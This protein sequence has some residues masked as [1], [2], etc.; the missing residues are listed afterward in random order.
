MYITTEDV[1]KQINVDFSDDDEYIGQLIEAAEQ[2]VSNYIN[3][4]LLEHTENGV[5]AAPLRQAIL[6]I[7]A[8]LYENREPVSYAKAVTVPF[9]FNYLVLPYVKLT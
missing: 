7:A 1:K 4:P 5:L 3:S 9:A 6:L 2:S 8:N